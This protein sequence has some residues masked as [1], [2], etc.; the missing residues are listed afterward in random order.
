M[1]LAKSDPDTAILNADS[2]EYFTENDPSL[3]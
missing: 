2:H 3:P 1:D